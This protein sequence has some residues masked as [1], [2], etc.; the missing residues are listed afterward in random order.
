MAKTD[1]TELR[2]EISAQDVAPEDIDQMTRQFL[3]E[4]RETDVES[5]QLAPGGP[6][7]AGTKS[8]DP[9][10]TGAIVMTVLPVVLPKVI[11]IAQSWIARGSGRTV[12]FKGKVGKQ[13]IE[14]EGPPEELK[15]LLDKLGR[16]K[17]K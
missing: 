14:F 10:T 12:K 15:K 9:V 2:L 8:V 5:V 17:K 16:D 1:L 6:A 7:P 11:D 4:L 13:V 3:S